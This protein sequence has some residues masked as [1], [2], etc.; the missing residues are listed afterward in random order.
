MGSSQPEERP[1]EEAQIA[2]L[3]QK[4]RVPFLVN[5]LFEHLFAGLQYM[6]CRDTRKMFKFQVRAWYNGLR[7]SNRVGRGS[8]RIE[9]FQERFAEDMAFA[10][11]GR[12]FRRWPGATKMS[13]SRTSETPKIGPA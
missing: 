7:T 11:T 4:G 8:Y 3:P 12:P 2:V 5:C 6:F 10:I 1:L 13:P 9:S